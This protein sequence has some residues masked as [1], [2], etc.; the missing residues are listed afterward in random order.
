ME[1]FSV[2]TTGEVVFDALI[3]GAAFGGNTSLGITGGGISGFAN[4]GLG[5]NYGSHP[6]GV[7]PSFGGLTDSVSS[8][9]PS[10][11]GTFWQNIFNVNILS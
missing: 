9:L 8:S 7:F 2:G 1:R 11:G 4:Y 10:L 3:G 5:C 6:T